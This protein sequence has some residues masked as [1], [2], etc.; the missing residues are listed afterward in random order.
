MGDAIFRELLTQM[1]TIARP[2]VELDGEGAPKTPAYEAIEDGVAARI[3][4][5]RTASADDLLGRDEDVT[6]VAYLE[7]T[8]LRPSDRLVMR[9]AEA[10]L[11]AD[12]D[13]GETV[14]SVSSTRLAGNRQRFATYGIL[15]VSASTIRNS[16]SSEGRK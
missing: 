12:A 7:P 1:A 16:V 13:A 8:D 5:A 15:D 2:R 14:L 10:S 4:R 11:V 9:T 6:H 3:G